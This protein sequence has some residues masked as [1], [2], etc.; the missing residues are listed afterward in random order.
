ML[1]DDGYITL[2]EADYTGGNYDL[3]IKVVNTWGGADPVLQNVELTEKCVAS[4]VTVDS[5]D[6][7]VFNAVETFTGE[8]KSESST[9]VYFAT[10]NPTACPITYTIVD[11]DGAPISADIAAYIYINECCG[12]V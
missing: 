2:N 4:T 12:E 7:I 3:A 6:A 11:T 8:L 10:S 5:A 1:T 9:S